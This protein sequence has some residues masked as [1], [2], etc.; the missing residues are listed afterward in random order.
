MNVHGVEVR[1]QSLGGVCPH[2]P[3]WSLLFTGCAEI[4]GLQVSR[5]F[6]VSSTNL[7]RK[8]GL[9]TLTTMSSLIYKG[10]DDPNLRPIIYP[11]NHLSSSSTL[12]YYFKKFYSFILTQNINVTFAVWAQVWTPHLFHACLPSRRGSHWPTLSVSTESLKLLS[13]HWWPLGWHICKH[14]VFSLCWE[15]ALTSS[16][17]HLFLP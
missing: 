13:V 6:S 12:K 5:D 7:I 3:L 15:D 4:A 11:L 1:K 9:Q 17:E 8:L 16:Y 10:S 14:I 2:L